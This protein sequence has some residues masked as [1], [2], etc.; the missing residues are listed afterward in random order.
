MKKTLLTILLLSTAA[1]VF[2]QTFVAPMRRVPPPRDA[3]VIQNRP[4][5]GAIQRGV[6][7][8]NPLQM[9]NPFA[10]REYGSGT[11]FVSTQRDPFQHPYGS[12]VRP[13]GVRLVTVEF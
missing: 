9:V 4:T 5:E 2:A 13:T 10:P 1:P 3:R 6:R 11:D 12:V 7:R 8:G